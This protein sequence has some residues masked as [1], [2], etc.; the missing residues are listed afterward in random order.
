MAIMM[1][2]KRTQAWS[3][4]DGGKMRAYAQSTKKEAE[5][6]GKTNWFC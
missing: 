4:P 6:E 5:K 3:F 1:L 2:T